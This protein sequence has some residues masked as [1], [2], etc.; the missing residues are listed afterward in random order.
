MYYA[1]NGPKSVGGRGGGGP[2]PPSLG[3]Q[4]MGANLPL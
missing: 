4:G 1:M 3:R 2:S